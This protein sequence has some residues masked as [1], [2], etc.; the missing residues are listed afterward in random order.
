M[1]PARK[2][3]GAGSFATF[4][5]I[6]PVCFFLGILFAQFPYDFPLLWTKAP[7]TSEYLDQ[8]TTHINFI[9]ESPPLVGR[10]LNIV[11]VVGLGGFL[12]KLFNPTEANV[13]FDGASLVLYLIGIGIYLTN[14]MKGLRAVKADIW[15]KPGWDTPTEGQGIILGKEDSLKVL[16]AS[17]TILALVLAGVLVLQAGQWYAESKEKEE[18]E[19]IDKDYAEKL[20]AAAAS[21]AKKKQ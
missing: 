17:N 20:K 10:L 6:G 3:H 19:K 9:L 4:V 7:I 21:P 18:Q 15:S 11:M 16:S 8:V 12:I 1:A 2:A 13:L 5:I 14:I